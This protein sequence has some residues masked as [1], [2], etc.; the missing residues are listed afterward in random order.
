MSDS[1]TPLESLT[2]TCRAPHSRILFVDRKT[3]T[4]VGDFQADG[5]APHHM[6]VDSK[7]NI[8]LAQLTAGSRK[9]AVA[10]PAPR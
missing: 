5:L 6:A 1:I 2:G 10:G 8:Y 7:G 3:L 9:L 4:V